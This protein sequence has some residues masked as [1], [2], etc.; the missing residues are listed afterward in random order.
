MR[1]YLENVCVEKLAL[2]CLLVFM[3]CFLALCLPSSV[4]SLSHEAIDLI[5]LVIIWSG[6]FGTVLALLEDFALTLAEVCH[7]DKSARS[8]RARIR[9]GVIFSIIPSFVLVASMVI[10]S[11]RPPF[12][13]AGWIFL[14]C[15][16]IVVT[17]AYFSLGWRVGGKVTRALVRLK[18]KY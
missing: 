13:P 18:K 11:V 5:V 6:I 17:P 8:V 3:T 15:F 4:L 7:A 9:V 12:K 1:S 10:L 2:I 16:V 14:I